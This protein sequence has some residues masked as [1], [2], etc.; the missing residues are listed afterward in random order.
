MIARALALLAC[1]AI[2]ACGMVEQ[3]LEPAYTPNSQ[4]ASLS[5]PPIA[6]VPSIV[7]VAAPQL[8]AN[9]LLGNATGSQ[10]TATSVTVPSCS[11]ANQG[12]N[13]T[14]ASGFGCATLGGGGIA[15]AL[16]APVMSS[17]PTSSGWTWL[18]QGGATETDS[19]MGIS[20]TKTTESSNHI[21][22]GYMRAV[23]VGAYEAK[24]L[25]IPTINGG[26][27]G[28]FVFGWYDGTNKL[29]LVNFQTDG[30]W[31]VYHTTYS[32]P[33]AQNA[34]SGVGNNWYMQ[35]FWVRAKDDGAGNFSLSIS[36]DGVLWYDV[37]ASTAKSGGYLGSSGYSN[38]FVG[39]DAYSQ[40]CRLTVASYAD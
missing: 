17:V 40:D 12:L 22:R 24:A 28:G 32:T 1:I 11:G 39:C 34:Q 20:F 6:K 30:I 4:V 38:I 3:D 9:S 36:A 2:A 14:S 10:R 25:L 37:V 16:F 8:P 27:Y 33:S 31:H 26:G 7:R 18:N 15:A 13:W 21:V 5:P 35:A 19:A 29:D 23:P